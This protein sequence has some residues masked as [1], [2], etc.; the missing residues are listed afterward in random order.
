MFNSTT[1]ARGLE[2]YQKSWASA[3]PPSYYGYALAGLAT[4]LLPTGLGMLGGAAAFGAAWATTGFFKAAETDIRMLGWI[5][6]PSVFKGLP[7]WLEMLSNPA[8]T[9][10]TYVA[11]AKAWHRFAVGMPDPQGNDF[12]LVL[13]K[14]STKFRGWAGKNPEG[15]VA[16]WL[17]D[18]A[19]WMDDA[20]NRVGGIL[21]KEDMWTTVRG[22]K[23]LNFGNLFHI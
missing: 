20:G 13:D 4:A 5:K 10:P 15:F 8:E 6:D 23:I 3:I 18:T 2:W 1:L 7:K 14:F 21:S 17:T 22:Q 11:T 19:D 9:N 12:K 16:K